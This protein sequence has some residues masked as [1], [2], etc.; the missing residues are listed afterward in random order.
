MNAKET[1]SNAM[2]YGFWCNEECAKR[3]MEQGIPPLGSARQSKQTQA[4][5]DLLL[6][7]AVSSQAGVDKKEFW[8]PLAVTGVVIGSLLGITLMVIG[9]KKF[10]KK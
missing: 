4:D 1:W 3:K 2:G 8:T 10:A 9:I 6:A 5:A 7:Q